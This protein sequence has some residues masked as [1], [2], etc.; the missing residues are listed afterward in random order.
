MTEPENLDMLV[1]LIAAA[2]FSLLIWWGFTENP[3]PLFGV[4]SQPGKGVIKLT[5][6]IKK[7]KTL[8]N[9]RH[10]LIC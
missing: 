9:I 8:P 3:S 6:T 1:E 4:Y 5:K 7:F 2:T 10:E